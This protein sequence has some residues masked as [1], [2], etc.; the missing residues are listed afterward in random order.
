MHWHFQSLEFP[1]ISVSPTIKLA[2]KLGNRH[3]VSCLM[4]ACTDGLSE[5]SSAA[6]GKEMLSGETQPIQKMCKRKIKIALTVAKTPCKSE[7]EL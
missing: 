3:F 2:H 5:K 6:A 1:I 7:G 4:G